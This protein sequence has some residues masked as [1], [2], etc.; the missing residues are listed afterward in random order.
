MCLL[1][2][3]GTWM[4]IREIRENWGNQGKSG[5]SG[6]ISSTANYM[7]PWTEMRLGAEGASNQA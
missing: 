3:P 5:K 4:K 1:M 2:E 6:K 7:A